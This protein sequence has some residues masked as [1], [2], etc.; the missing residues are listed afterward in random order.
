M[1]LN[2]KERSSGQHVGQLKISKRGAGVVRLYLYFATLRII[3]NDVNLKL[4]YEEK[5]RRDGGKVKLK[6]LIAVMRKMVKGLWAASHH[7]EAFDSSKLVRLIS[8]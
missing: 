1:G 5:V 7:G 6:A 3:Q 4:W 2:L 8:L